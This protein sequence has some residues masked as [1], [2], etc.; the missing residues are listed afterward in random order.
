MDKSKEKK[1]TPP[2]APLTDTDTPP[3]TDGMRQAMEDQ[4]EIKM[5]KKMGESYDKALK[6]YKK[7]GKVSSASSRA[8]GCAVKGKTRGRMM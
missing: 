8:D 3:M 7:G 4:K 2:P 5:R 6:T 1:V